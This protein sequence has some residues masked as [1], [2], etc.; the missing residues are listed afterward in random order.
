M[1]VMFHNFERKK[2]KIHYEVDSACLQFIH[3]IPTISLWLL[4]IFKSYDFI[5][6][7]HMY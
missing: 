4:S 3:N 6:L 7:D 2:V 5:Y 1:D